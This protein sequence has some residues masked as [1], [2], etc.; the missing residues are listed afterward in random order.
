MSIIPGTIISISFTILSGIQAQ[1]DR[2]VGNLFRFH[3]LS[4]YHELESSP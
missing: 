3:K 1:I 2:H 4:S